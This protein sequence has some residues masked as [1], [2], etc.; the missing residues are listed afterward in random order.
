MNGRQCG[1]SS[2]QG[3]IG[4]DQHALASS[5]AFPFIVTGAGSE[6]KWRHLPRFA[7]SETPC[8]GRSASTS[9]D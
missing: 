5:L 3:F 6:M 7:K 1:L 8:G 4:L 9:V 2:F